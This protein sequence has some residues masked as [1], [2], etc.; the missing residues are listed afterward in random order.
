MSTGRHDTDLT[1]WWC[2]NLPRF[3]E[4]ADEYRWRHLLDA[5]NADI[6][7]G[8]PVADALAAHHLPIDPVDDLSHQKSWYD[9]ANLD[10]LRPVQAVPVVGRYTCPAAVRRCGRR[11]DPDRATGHE[12]RCGLHGLPMTRHAPPTGGRP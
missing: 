9:P 10:G 8:V 6:R 7:A 3:T 2:E 12:P 1:A 4:H 11:D 5:A